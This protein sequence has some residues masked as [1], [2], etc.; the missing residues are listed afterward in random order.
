MKCEHFPW[1]LVDAAGGIHRQID[2]VIISYHSLTCQTKIDRLRKKCDVNN[3]FTKVKIAI[4]SSFGSRVPMNPTPL[5]SI[6]NNVTHSGF[7]FSV[8]Y[9]CFQSPCRDCKQRAQ[10]VTANSPIDL[11][12][13]W[14]RR[15]A[16][17][18]RF[19][20][21]CLWMGAMLWRRDEEPKMHIG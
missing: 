17:F 21:R 5:H 3:G 18:W 1:S 9:I 13:P 4:N 20:R 14:Q 16:L 8:F 19:R 12:F 11:F 10:L 2:Y 7:A 6:R 15:E